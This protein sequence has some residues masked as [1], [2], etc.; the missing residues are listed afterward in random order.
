MTRPIIKVENLSKI[1]DIGR[2]GTGY[3]TFRELVMQALGSPLKFFG[4]W[5]GKK[6]EKFYALN[7]VSFEVQPGEVVG[8]IG[9]NGAGKS[10]LLKV[11]SRITE[12]SSGGVDLWGRLSSL[13]EVG[14]GF[15]P[16]LTGRENIYLNG[17]ILGM[18]RTEIHRKFDDIVT[19]AEVEKF[20]DTPVKRYSSGMYLRLAFAVAAHLEPEILLVDEVLAVGDNNFQ[21]KCLGKMEEL[22]VQ[23]RTVLFVSHNMPAVLRLC[24]RV[25]LLDRGQVVADGEAQQITR[26]Y[27]HSDSGSPAERVWPDD[28]TAPGDQIARLQSVTVRNAQGKVAEA[29]DICQPFQIEVKYRNLQQVL[30]P[31]VFLQ[32][33][34]EDGVLLFQTNDYNNR[35]WWQLR[36]EPG[37]VHVV[38]H[39]PGNFFAEGRIFVT[40]GIGTYNPNVLHALEHDAVAF[41]VF[42][43]SEGIGVRGDYVGEWPGVLRPMLQWT[44]TTGTGY[45]ADENWDQ[46]QSSLYLTAK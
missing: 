32:F 25:I 28:E 18:R 12:P 24:N 42:D 34:N 8:L 19:F 22:G 45:L 16:E 39:I 38:C 10:T 26:L 4:S 17:A 36:R 11:L 2:R 46:S 31:T 13:L 43:R 33:R 23:G 27:L 40:A 15:H 3:T 7:D 35:R 21:K 9:R 20:I 6:S 14:T 44:V 37:P 1:Y 41:Q 5:Q 29:I 30:R